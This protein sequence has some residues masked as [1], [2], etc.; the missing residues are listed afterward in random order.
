MPGLKK[1]YFFRSCALNLGMSY[2]QMI[3]GLAENRIKPKTSHSGVRNR[4]QIGTSIK[5]PILQP[6]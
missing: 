5:N 3:I 4:Q 2:E 6:T 1:G